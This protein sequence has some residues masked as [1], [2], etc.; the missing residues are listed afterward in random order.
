ML[1]V[2]LLLLA[3]SQ[4]SRAKI[5]IDINPNVTYQTFDGLGISQAFQRARQIYGSDG[6]SPPNTQ[7]VLDLLFNNKTGAGLTIL[8]NGIGS[9]VHGEYDLMKSIAPSPPGQVPVPPPPPATNA[10]NGSQPGIVVMPAPAGPLPM[11]Q[12]NSTA[13]HY[14]WDNDDSGQLRLTWDALGRGLRT[15][16]ADAWSAP[17]WM[18]SN[19][20]DSRGGSLCGVAGVK[21][22]QGDMRLAYAVYLVQHLKFYQQAGVKID[23][24]GFLNEP[25]FK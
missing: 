12:W 4:L 22:E 3:A 10:S 15:V 14:E 1:P 8:R 5:V 19:L 20:N 2:T 11:A 17:A 23:Y 25:D 21:C 16:Y 13:P 24:L 6:L 18:K 7:R 9:S